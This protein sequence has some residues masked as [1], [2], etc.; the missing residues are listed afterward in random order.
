ML[1]PVNHRIEAHRSIQGGA[2]RPSPLRNPPVQRFS[3]VGS[4]FRTA[5][6]LL[7]VL[8]HQWRHVCALMIALFLAHHAW[9][10]SDRVF[11]Y[12]DNQA[13]WLYPAF[14]IALVVLQL[15][16]FQRLIDFLI[17]R[18]PERDNSHETTNPPQ[19]KDQ[20]R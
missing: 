12:P 11:H 13:V 3:V 17:P 7:I 4:L 1:G 10:L 5:S 2:P 15:R 8:C 6:W 16:F 18:I 19:P 14:V 9:N 20:T